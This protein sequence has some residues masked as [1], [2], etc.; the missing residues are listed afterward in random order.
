MS[1][2]LP[3]DEP[4][5]DAFHNFQDSFSI[6]PFR[7]GYPVEFLKRVLPIQCHS[8]NDY[9]RQRPLFSAL[10]TG[11]ISVE[12]DVWLVDDDLLVGHAEGEL[13]HERTLQSLYIDP[14]VE[15]LEYMNLHT[16]SDRTKELNGVFY[17]D[18]AQTLVLL[19]DF[20]TPDIWSHAV[21]QLGPLRERGYLT[22]WNGQDRI[23]RP[24]TVVVSGS[25]PF[26]L[27]T[28]NDTYRDIFYDAPL[29]DLDEWDDLEGGPDRPSSVLKY[30]PSNSYYASANLF[31]AIGALPGFSFTEPQT[32]LLRVQIG[33]AREQ[34]L[35]PR[36]WGIPRWPRGLRDRIWDVLIHE[37]TGVLNVDDL[38]AARKGMWYVG[39]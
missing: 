27:L 11:C 26:H 30:N 13:T 20:K 2:G 18:P 14:L 6:S 37:N 29:G 12:A 25:T 7:P 17:Q 28:L 16:S 15:V 38:R 24:I 35:V 8:H 36:Y 5:D 9:W 31:Q 34:G 3:G 21:E 39:H 19:I 1:L 32:E 4:F 23:M 10:G 22:T 33:R